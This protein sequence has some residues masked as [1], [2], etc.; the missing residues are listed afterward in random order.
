LARFQRARPNSEILENSSIGVL[1]LT[2][3]PESYSWR[4]MPV[5]DLPLDDSGDGECHD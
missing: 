4:F 2:L 3:R 1:T 5:A